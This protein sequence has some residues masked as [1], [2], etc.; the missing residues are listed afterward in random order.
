MIYHC[1]PR[2]VTYQIVS[3]E[4]L[5]DERLKPQAIGVMAYLLG[6]PKDWEIIV[7][8]L[9]KRFQMSEDSIGTIF[10]Q[11]EK[12]GYARLVTVRA[13]SGTKFCGKQWE[14]F[15][16]PE[17][18][19]N[20]KNTQPVSIIRQ[21]QREFS[22]KSKRSDIGKNRPSEKTVLIN[23]EEEK[24]KENLL[25][26][27][28]CVN[29]RAGSTTHTIFFKNEEVLSVQKEPSPPSCAPPPFQKRGTTSDQEILFRDSIYA[30][31]PEGVL[32]LRDALLARHPRYEKAHWY[33]Y[34]K[35]LLNWSDTSLARR[36][37]WVA[38][39]ASFID[40]DDAKGKLMAR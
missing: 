1:D 8:Q 26:N 28:E 24:N 25:K 39:A 38:Q 37:D 30:P 9:A 20:F 10:K 13:H 4:I 22:L 31:I 32:L 17:L 15:E 35:R 33:N 18:N 21:P 12:L 36:I 40:G 5:D 6:R 29:E 11:L 14:V 2:P 34:H 16:N 23:N 27:K 7:S 3:K 19:P